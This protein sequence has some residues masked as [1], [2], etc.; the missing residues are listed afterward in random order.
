MVQEILQQ[1]EALPPEQRI[2]LIREL[3]NTLV[4]AQPRPEHRKLVYGMFQEG[5]MSTEED[6][7]LAEW[8]P[9]EAELNGD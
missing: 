9:S 5:R 7:K 2:W 8:H 6:F 4:T 1:A 3:A